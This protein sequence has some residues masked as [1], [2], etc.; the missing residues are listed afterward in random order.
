M[1]TQDSAMMVCYRECLSNMAKFNSGDDQKITQFINNIERIGKMIDAKDN[2][3]YCMCTA[4]LE[5]EAKRWYEDQTP[6]S[7]WKQLKKALIERFKSSDST[8]KIFEQLRDRKQ[9]PEETTNSYYDAIIRLCHEYDSTMSQKLKISW[10]ENG[11]KDS[12][13]IPTK[14]Q[15]KLLSEEEHTTQ[16]FLKVAKDEQELQEESPSTTEANSTSHT[17]YFAN[18]VATTL[19]PT[20]NT[21]TTPSNHSRASRSTTSHQ[22]QRS[23]RSQKNFET[24]H[25]QSSQTRYP[26]TS[27]RSYSPESQR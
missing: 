15:M 10:L 14:R 3:L 9:K 4:K 12:L 26:S 1:S 6:A 25:R 18:T 13:K 8:S 27:Q 2:I 17:P 24:P 23:Y 19:R 21:S 16:M 5:G 11:I 20:E 22:L 7:D